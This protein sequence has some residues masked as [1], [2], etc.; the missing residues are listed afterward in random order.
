M[1]IT[2]V[3]S[4]TSEQG[5][6]DEFTLQWAFGLVRLRFPFARSD[7]SVHDKKAV[8]RDTDRARSSS[9]KR[10]DFFAAIRQ[11][12]FRRRV[13]RL[14]RDLWRAVQKK[15]VN[16]RIRLGL[17][18][19]ADTGQLWALLGPV[20]GVLTSVQDASIHLEPEFFDTTI[21]VE[22]S[23]SLRFIP[24]QIVYLSLGLLLS[25]TIWQGIRH[26]R[27]RGD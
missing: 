23:G 22:S 14:I 16:I 1:P 26:T 10:V 13:T 3:F 24:L 17:G 19:P 25:P 15:N 21:D 5:S 27:I 2:L 12:T 9:D 7:K 6:K 18:D 4:V 11:A 20:A 8:T